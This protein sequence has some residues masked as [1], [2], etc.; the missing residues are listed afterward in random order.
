[1]I[2]LSTLFMTLLT[3]SYV[4][5]VLS[6]DSVFVAL[7]GTFVSTDLFLHIDCVVEQFTRRASCKVIFYLKLTLYFH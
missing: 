1:M 4:L 6:L 7:S 3:D 5:P 2:T